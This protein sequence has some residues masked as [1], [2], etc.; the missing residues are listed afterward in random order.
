MSQNDAPESTEPLAEEVLD[1]LRGEDPPIE[2]DLT[3]DQ[4]EAVSGGVRKAGGEPP[5]YTST[6]VEI[7]AI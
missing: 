5:E 7:I 3:D 1:T 6:K 2:G 4:L